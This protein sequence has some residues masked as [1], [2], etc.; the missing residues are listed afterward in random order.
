MVQLGFGIQI[1]TLLWQDVSLLQPLLPR[2]KREFIH[3][4]QFSQMRLFLAAGQMDVLGLTELITANSCGR[5]ITHIREEWQ[6][7]ASRIIASSF[8][9]AAWR[10]KLEYG[11]SDQESWFH[12]WK[13]I[14][15]GWQKFNS[16]LMTSTYWHVH[17]ID[18]FSVGTWRQRSES[19]P[20]PNAWEASMD[21][22]LLL[23]T[24]TS[25]SV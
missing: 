8:A 15:A 22:Q 9:Q 23:L 14:L 13:N 21:S 11:K 17:V 12:I 6:P 7:F 25:T 20:R 10:V 24:T 5:L 1:I 2:G 4:V 3:T 18:Q 19:P 16:S